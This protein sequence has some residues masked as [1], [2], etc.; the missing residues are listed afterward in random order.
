MWLRHH[1]IDEAP[2][3]RNLVLNVCLGK[4]GSVSRMTASRRLS[5]A[6][7][8]S[9]VSVVQQCAE[10][11]LLWLLA[12]GAVKNKVLLAKARE[13]QHLAKSLGDAMC[14]IGCSP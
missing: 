10:N 2:A 7:V 9:A 13:A 11:G 12:I 14:G 1:G 6:R 5:S 4:L 3:T 8:L